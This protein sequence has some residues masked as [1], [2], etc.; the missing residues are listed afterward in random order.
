MRLLS[1][2]RPYTAPESSY[3]LEALELLPCGTTQDDRSFVLVR[4]E[5]L[6]PEVIE[7]DH[8][9]LSAKEAIENAEQFYR[10]KKTSWYLESDQHFKNNLEENIEIIL[11]H[12]FNNLKQ[13]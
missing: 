4:Y 6:K 10:I 12:H 8:F 2:D 1:N 9:F 13:K 11:E 3:E 7:G 5:S